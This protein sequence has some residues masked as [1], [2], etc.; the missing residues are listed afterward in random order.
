MDKKSATPQKESRK[1]KILTLQQRVEVLQWHEKGQ[2]CRAIAMKLD[3]GKTQIQ[4]IINS[5]DSVLK[6]WQSG[7]GRSDRR[8]VKA[9]K[10]T[11]GELNKLV[12]EW[13]CTA[14][15]KQIP[16]TGPLLQ[17]KASM[18]CLEMPHLDENDL[19]ASN[20]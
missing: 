2:S 18:L 1:R 17:E 8:Y 6:E 16:V 13:F 4:S 14:R 12:W 11:Y 3:V 10:T 20:G 5:G 9:R 15:S 19:S 7:E